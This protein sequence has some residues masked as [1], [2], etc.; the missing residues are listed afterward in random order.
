MTG[1]LFFPLRQIRCVDRKGR[2]RI[3]NAIATRILLPKKP[4]VFA[5]IVGA[6][7][8]KK[9][10]KK[11]RTTES[12]DHHHSW[13]PGQTRA[14]S[15]SILAFQGRKKKG[16]GE[17]AQ[18]V[19]DPLPDGRVQARPPRAE[20]GKGRRMDQP[21]QRRANASAAVDIGVLRSPPSIRDR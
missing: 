9:G 3:G 18:Q 10:G 19:N 8:E 2:E 12:P 20:K 21:I 11:D 4:T 17:K 7:E 13:Q 15:C 14:R 16:G 5:L 6:K 1:G